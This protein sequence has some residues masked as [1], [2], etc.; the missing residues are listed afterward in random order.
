MSQTNNRNSGKSTDARNPDGTFAQGNPGKPKG[1]RHRA[2]QAIE[3]MLEGQREALTQKAI[4]LALEG[5]VTA[6]RLCLDRIAPVR[7]DAPVSFDLPDI[8]TAEDAANAARAILRAVAEGE[9]TPMEA[10]TV[11]GVVE[12]FRRTLETTE[13]ERRIAALEATESKK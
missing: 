5:D 6:L 3:Q 13:M 9:V 2:T 8:E 4:D 12:Q 11:M 10:A 1:S 7:K